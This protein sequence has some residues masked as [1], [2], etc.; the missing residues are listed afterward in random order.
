MVAKDLLDLRM[1][2]RAQACL[3]TSTEWEGLTA[4]SLNEEPSTPAGF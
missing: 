3:D 1:V 4:P 2:S